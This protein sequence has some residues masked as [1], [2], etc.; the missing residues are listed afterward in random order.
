MY[1]L[2]YFGY[3]IKQNHSLHCL[4]WLASFTVFKVYSHYS[5]Y[6]SISFHLFLFIHLFIQPSVV[7]YVG[8]FT[9]II[10]AAVNIHLQ[11][12]AWTY[13]FIS[14][15][16]IPRRQTCWAMCN[17]VFSKE[18]P[19]FLNS[20]QQ[21][22]QIP[23]SPHFYRHLFSLFFIIAILVYVKWDHLELELHFPDS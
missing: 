15:G 21:L 16:F 23:T 13:I 22:V 8:C 7:A 6:T 14:S 3:F 12:L 1:R 9:I 18:A 5:T 11:S 10:N 17:S 20:H 2:A 19:S 4:L